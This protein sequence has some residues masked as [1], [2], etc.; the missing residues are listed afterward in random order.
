MFE[1]ENILPW[2]YDVYVNMASNYIE[3]QESK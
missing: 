3:N 1:L 2:E